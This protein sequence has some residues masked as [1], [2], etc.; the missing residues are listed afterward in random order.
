MSSP[1]AAAGETG[2]LP[3]GTPVD[4]TNCERQPIH[5]P[6]SIQPRGVLIVVSDPDFV[7]DQVS[8]NLAD[9]VGTGWKDALGR[10]LDQVLGRAAVEAVVRSASAVGDL[11]ASRPRT[12]A[13]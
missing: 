8:E 9:L 3:L 1:G 2:W 11:P 12:P 13:R 5:I 6:G 7:V 10:P 4:L